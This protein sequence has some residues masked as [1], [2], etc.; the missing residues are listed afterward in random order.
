[1]PK[2]P[3]LKFLRHVPLAFAL[4]L[5]WGAMRVSG[6]ALTAGNPLTWL[7]VVGSFVTL[8]LEFNKSGDISLKGFEKDQALSVPATFAVG[9]IGMWLWERGTWSILDAFVVIV[10]LIDGYLS[11]VNAFRTALRK[12]TAGVQE[13]QPDPDHAGTHG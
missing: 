11:P 2:I 9:M 10:V 1:M 8:V 6:L 5:V 7:V 3:N 13:A 4:I 12:F